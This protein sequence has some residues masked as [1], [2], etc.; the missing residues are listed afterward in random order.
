MVHLGCQLRKKLCRLY[1]RLQHTDVSTYFFL[2]YPPTPASARIY[3]ASDSLY[4]QGLD[5]TL[6]LRQ[7][8]T[9]LRL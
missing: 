8:Y 7:L 9:Q 6:H 3:I 1:L 5:R 4:N 2:I